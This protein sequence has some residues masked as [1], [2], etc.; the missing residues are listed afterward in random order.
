M[1]TSAP[2][3][4]SVE[5]SN[6]AKLSMLLIDGGTA[7]LRTIFDRYY[8]PANLAA[9][10]NANFKTLKTLKD[11]K[12]LNG[13][14]WDKLFPR[15][16][17]APDSRNFDIT[18]L[19]LLLTNICGLSSPVTGWQKL[20]PSSDT[21]LEA[22]LAR[23]KFYRNEM[24]GHVTTTGIQTA[25]FNAKWTAISN[26]LVSLGLNQ[27][28]VDRLKTQPSGEDYVTAVTEWMK[29]DKEIK[30]QLEELRQDQ[31]EVLCIQQEQRSAQQ[32]THQAVEEGLCTVQE[33]QGIL[34]DISQAVGEMQRTQEE[35]HSALLF[36]QK[37]LEGIRENQD[38]A[39]Q[40]QIKV[41]EIQQHDHMTLQATQKGVEEIKE[42]IESLEKNEAVGHAEEILRN[43]VRSEF[44]GDIEH[45]ANKF[46]QG[47]REWI[48]KSVENWIDDRRSTNRVMVISGNAGMGKTVIAAVVSKRMQQ[49]GR[50]SGC[51]FC[52]HNIARYRNPQLMLQSLASHLSHSVPEYKAAL[53]QQLSRNLGKDL[54]NMNVEDLF[55]VLFK[56]PL[57][58][59]ADHDPGRNMLLVV[60]GLDESEHQGRNDLLDVMGR[61][62]CKLPSWIRFLV[63]TR[64]ERNILEALKHLN[65]IQL[66]ENQQENLNDIR[67]LFEMQLG[68][69]LGNENKSFLLERLLE[70]SEGLFLYA[71]FLIDFI[72]KKDSVLNL[73]QL[74]NTLPEGISSVYLSYFSRFEKEL[75]DELKVEEEQVLRFLCAITASREP[76]PIEFASK[77]FVPG[78]RS[79]TTQR[80]VNKAIACISTLL[81]IR[82][83]H[84]HFFHKSVKDWLTG[85]S[86][87]SQHDF[88]VDE[89]EGHEILF[90]LCSTEME[91]VKG[92]GFQ[93][94]KFENPERYALQ[95]GVQHMFEMEDSS[96]KLK[97]F[98]V[99]DGVNDYV[100]D[101]KLIY[102]KLCVNSTAATND[103]VSA[104]KH[105]KAVWIND[106]TL[107]LLNS[108]L[109]LLRKHSYVL[110]DYPHLFIQC[111]LNEGGPE[112]SSKA[113]KIFESHLTVLPHMEYTGKDE[114]KGADQAR[115]YCSGEVVCFDVSPELDYMVCEC[116][117]ST[118]HL[119]SLQTG[120]RE[121]VRPSLTKREFFKPS[122]LID[123]AYRLI[124]GRVN[125]CLSF[126]RCVVFHPNGESVLPGTLQRAYNL[127]GELTD[128]FPDSDCSFSNCAF[129]ADKE[130]I[131]TDFPRDGQ[132]LILWSM[133]N[134]EPLLGVRWMEEIASF[135]IA[136]NLTVIAISDIAGRV[137]LID[138]Q[139]QCSWQVL[140]CRDVVCGLLHFTS[141]EN[142]LVCG[143][144][145]LTK[146]ELLC[147]IHGLKFSKP[148]TFISLTPL[149][150]VLNST[151]SRPPP[152][153]PLQKMRFVLWPCNPCNLSG[154]DFTEQTSS[155][156]WVDRVHR[157]FPSLSAG[158]YMNLSDETVL[159]SSPGNNHVTMIN[160][161]LLNE[162]TDPGLLKKR[163]EEIVFAPEADFIYSL[164]H[165]LEK[166]DASSTV[167][168]VE[169]TVWRM[170]S[171]KVTRKEAFSTLVTLIPTKLGIVVLRG[172]EA[173]LRN[174]ELSKV[175]R[176]LTK[177]K[178]AGDL[179]PISDTTI[180]CCKTVRRREQPV[181]ELFEKPG[182]ASRSNAVSELKKLI[183]HD[184][185]S[186]PVLPKVGESALNILRDWEASIKQ[187]DESL[188]N[189]IACCEVRRPSLCYTPVWM[190]FEKSD[191]QSSAECDDASALQAS[192]EVQQ[193][194]LESLNVEGEI[195]LNGMCS[196]GPE[197]DSPFAIVFKVF[198]V[199]SDEFESSFETIFVDDCEGCITAVSSNR[200]HQFLVCICLETADE[201]RVDEKVSITL[202]SDGSTLW[203]RDSL[204]TD[205]ERN[206]SN[207]WTSHTSMRFSPQND[208]VVTWNSLARGRGLH[209]LDA[210]TGKTCHVFL[211][212]MDDIVDCKFV[213][214]ECLVCCRKE[215]FLTLF[216][217]RKGVLLSLLDI[218]EQ[219]F[220]LGACLHHPLVAVGLENSK[221]KFVRVHLPGKTQKKTGE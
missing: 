97:D 13:Y 106:Q 168:R 163:V 55:A 86:C 200:Q 186:Q 173:E 75:R 58:M 105:V 157:L 143:F 77:I 25:E 220:C 65:P 88:I 142:T 162:E 216:D 26:V 100:T 82:D 151:S 197:D 62:F 118:V 145:R 78:G 113:A 189:L 2:L 110:R 32:D 127:N 92:K 182:Q 22:N 124:R 69:Q 21:S 129:T 169:V 178:G 102:A 17:A 137:V 87:Y 202:R 24:Y 1:A 8:T 139:K 184:E 134:G 66:E 219:P 211:K 175:I 46:Q 35:N 36:A 207:F 194:I 171:G 50:L 153:L 39:Q 70:K 161:T 192:A 56:E 205:T 108:L 155:S 53:V 196:P 34:K 51:H 83:G 112:L 164:V 130:M 107:S 166:P 167:R 126:Y 98:N 80:R 99:N 38:K 49:A 210:R 144:L 132:M 11:R 180:A 148:P 61:H 217:I 73:E 218:G 213:E 138:P 42:K 29:S 20:P 152:F 5:K 81:P 7:I 33:N 154:H 27:S 120:N 140:L 114:H 43:L 12:I 133:E 104:Q 9:G 172:G 150:E 159:I 101:L 76:L 67:I 40:M 117:D 31:E 89:R 149:K 170:S 198:N 84:I 195:M 181:R 103:L 109:N 135:A 193:D 74:E 209:I 176:A 201:G 160:T 95:H 37:S 91:N 206:P 59:L 72:Q 204:W 179:F 111:L 18:L 48:F 4:S 115:F 221:L 147:G 119:W 122:E 177:L 128:L 125:C 190:E 199:S 212:T 185:L 64:P 45:H 63:T 41:C 54:N 183:E 71:Y 136:Q 188:D 16:K 165:F 174:F 191:F 23:V 30:S 57:S 208:F 94:P 146:E 187:S 60:D 156:C 6:G 121:W 203:R 52:Q 90:K 19:F 79:L 141:D 28:E 96:N 123:S 14:Q 131:F 215:N 47:T 44:R 3:A 68:T 158:S 214:N 10:L 85:A 93:E 15:C 116:R